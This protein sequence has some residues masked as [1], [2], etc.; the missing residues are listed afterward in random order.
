MSVCDISRRYFLN[1]TIFCLFPKFEVLFTII[2]VNIKVRYS[3][4]DLDIFSEYLPAN[5]VPLA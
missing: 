5:F 4:I 3:N 1:T 2:I